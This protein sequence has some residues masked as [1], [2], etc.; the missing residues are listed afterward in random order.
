MKGIHCNYRGGEC[1]NPT[2]AI[3]GKCV[4]LIT[5]T[6]YYESI[7][8]ENTVLKKELYELKELLPDAIKEYEELKKQNE[9]LKIAFQTFKEG[10]SIGDRFYSDV[11]WDDSELTPFQKALKEN[12]EL[13]LKL[14]GKT[15]FDEKEVLE[16]QL[17]KAKERIEFLEMQLRH[18]KENKNTET[19]F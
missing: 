11:H 9:E 16:A 3:K 1:F 17:D 7:V 4:D 14:S 19:P 8:T 5:R 18:I 2:C 12:E 6:D 10:I 15:F 13:K